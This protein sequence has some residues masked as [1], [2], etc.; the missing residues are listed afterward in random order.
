MHP[1][2]YSLEIPCLPAKLRIGRGH[3]KWLTRIFKL[4]FLGIF[5]IIILY[6]HILETILC[7]TTKQH[8]CL[9][10]SSLFYQK[11][12]QGH[13]SAHIYL[14]YLTSSK[15][16]SLASLISMTLRIAIHSSFL[17]V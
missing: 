4:F 10:E 17:G 13:D 5:D 14:W 1:D 7:N 2:S 12:S 8:V 11:T 15:D 9:K 16:T 3:T 6:I